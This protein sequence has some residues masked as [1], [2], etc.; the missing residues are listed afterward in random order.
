MCYQH[1]YKYNLCG[2]FW[3][4][5]A[6]AFPAGV[7]F[8]E[9]ED[10]L[11][12]LFKRQPVCYWMALL[13]LLAVFSIAYFTYKPTIWPVCYLCIPCIVALIVARLPI[14]KLSSIPAV[15]FIS[16]VS[17]EIYL[18][19]GIPM[20]LFRQKFSIH[21]DTLFVCAVYTVTIL[22]AYLVHLISARIYKAC[23]SSTT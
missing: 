12:M 4:L 22:L 16:A 18:C 20:E 7:V 2:R 23:I 3:W 10:R 14:E 5:C 17:Y 6:L 8:A 11:Y 1:N 13:L 9:S 19:Q 15:A 21:S